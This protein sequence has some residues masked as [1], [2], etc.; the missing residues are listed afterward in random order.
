MNKPIN[1]AIN[2]I[3]KERDVSLEQIAGEIGVSSMTVYRWQRGQ[4]KPKSRI[5]LRALTEYINRSSKN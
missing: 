3:I 1:E 4:A 5:V 2:Q